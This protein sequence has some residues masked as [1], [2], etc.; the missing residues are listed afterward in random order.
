MKITSACPA[1]RKTLPAGGVTPP[2]TAPRWRSP[3][4]RSP[5]YHRLGGPPPGLRIAARA[6]T[7][8]HLHPPLPCKAPIAGCKAPIG[9]CKAP[10]GRCKASIGGG[11]AP[12][13][14]C[15]AG[16]ARCKAPI[17]R[18]KPGVARCKPGIAR[19]KPGMRSSKEGGG[20]CVPPRRRRGRG[21]SRPSPHVMGVDVGAPS[22]TPCMWGRVT[23]P[24]S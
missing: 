21:A 11:K 7:P 18:C 20:S 24:P 16:V 3:L 4:R 5:R 17:G 9:R 2:R 22:F 1:R 13:G 6:T 12:I 15:K 8:G 23:N 14:R 19:C 10:I